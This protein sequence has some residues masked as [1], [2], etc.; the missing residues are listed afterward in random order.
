IGG[1]EAKIVEFGTNYIK[2]V[3]PQITPGRHELY[4]VNN[5]FGTSNRVFINFEGSKITIDKIVGDTGKKQGKDNVEILGSGFQNTHMGIL[6][7][8]NIKDS[9]MP[10]VRFGTIGDIKD[11][12][13]NRAQVVL[14]NGDF[15]LEYDSSTNPVQVRMEAKYNKEIYFNTFSIYDYDGAPIYLP[16]WELKTTHG[17]VYPGY[18]LVKIEDKNRKLTV[19]KG[20]SPET[21]LINS[22]QIALKTPSYYTVGYVEVEVTNPDGGR[23]TTRYRYTNPQS[24]PRI[25]NITKD[26]MDPSIGDDGNTRIIRLDYR[27]GQ[28]I[29]VLGEDFRE[30]ARIQIGNILNIENKDITET[31]NASP[32]KLSFTMPGVNENAVGKL[33]RLTVINGDGAQT[34]SDDINN[35]WNAPIYFQ[36]IKGESEPELGSIVPDRGPATGGT[37]VTIKGKDFREKMEGYEGED[38]EIFFGD[39]KVPSKDI[40]IVDHSTIEV[41][42]PESQKLGPVRV[43]VENPDGSLTQ[44]DL[45][46]TYISKP[47]IDDVNPKKLF[48]ND[49]KTEVTITGSQ[50]IKGAKVIVGGNIIPI[51]DLKSGMDVKGQGITGVDSQGNNREVAVIGG[52]EGSADVVSENEIKVRF[53]EAMDLEN[54]SIIIINPDG[55]VSDPYDDFKYEKPVPLKPMVLEAIPGYESTVMLIWNKSEEDLLNK[56]TKYEIYGRKATESA[57]TFIATTTDAQYLVKGL[58]PDTEYIFQVRAL[59]QYGAA[60]DF[61]EVKVK[62]L[63]LQEDY[64]QREKE[65][66]LKDEEK[67][68]IEKGKEEIVGNKIIRTLGTEDIKNKVANLDFNQSKYKDTTELIINIPIALARTDSTLNI[69]YGELQMT[70]N[71]KDMYTYRVSALDKGDKDSNLQINIKRQGEDHIPRGKRLA[72]RAYEFYFGF[73][74][75]KNTIDID[76]LLRTGKLTI[77]LDNILYPDAKNVS[78]YRFD[79]PTGQYVK[80]SNNRTTSFNEKGKYILLSNR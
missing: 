32:N 2:V 38:L 21:K 28:H 70:I 37:K 54:T 63:S 11:I 22:G 31:L 69:K 52:M 79:I 44:Q 46:F 9:H 17:K 51:N 24:K 65:Q 23:A 40:K 30:G 10:K 29:T 80:I 75:G 77:N 64:K 59:N 67:K 3:T 36:F 74:V 43:K 6:E 61:A 45:K 72:S 42:V 76:K 7:N 18:E 1:I 50:F 49:D 12:N 16:T 14:E 48:I 73:Q 13:N 66:E 53:K 35:I 34:S 5:D 15:K 57:S 58:E 78:L 68:L 33:Y 56:A 27:G 26:G 8:N 4:V 20:Y 60:I 71:P 41:I 39:N 62:T 47:R 25:I 19:E 55:G